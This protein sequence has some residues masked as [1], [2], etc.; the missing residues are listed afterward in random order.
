MAATVNTHFLPGLIGHDK[1]Q[2]VQAYSQQH[3]RWAECPLSMFFRLS[4][5]RT[6][7]RLQLFGQDQVPH[8][9][10]KLGQTPAIRRVIK[11]FAQSSL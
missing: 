3:P 2:G 7:S 10:S 4:T 8:R 6:Q 1:S 5:V 11:I 9:E